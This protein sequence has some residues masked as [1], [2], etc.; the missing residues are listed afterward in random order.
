MTD[1]AD[2]AAEIEKLDTLRERGI[3]TNAEFTV[4][5]AE[6]IAPPIRKQPPSKRRPGMWLAI[7]IIVVSVVVGGA[8]DNNALIF[9]TMIAL[10]LYL[11]PALIAY[12]RAHHQRLAVFIV[13]LLLGWS[14]LGWIAALIWACTATRQSH[15]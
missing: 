15:D 6:L 10:A 1:R 13:N 9:A 12:Q 2:V 4:R 14:V 7:F 3:I 8:Y 5:K 11:L